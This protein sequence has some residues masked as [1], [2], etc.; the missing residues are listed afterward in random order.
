MPNP[1]IQVSRLTKYFPIKTGVFQRTAGWIKA[2]DGISFH[3]RS[4]EMLGLVGE[5]GCGKS[6]AGKA[7]INLERPTAG[8]VLLNMAPEGDPP[9]YV[10]IT[11]LNRRARKRLRQK[12]Q[13]IFQNPYGSL[14][15]RMTVN[16]ML[17]EIINYY[18]LAPS[19]QAAHE[20]ILHLLDRVGLHPE[21]LNK[22]PHEFSG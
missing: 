10:D 9:Q 5:S 12:V 8:E 11:R 2:V 16:R 4:G 15:P 3:I 19:A 7:M 18:D 14:N 22:Y 6:T 20:R 17:K 21:D 1:L 13:I